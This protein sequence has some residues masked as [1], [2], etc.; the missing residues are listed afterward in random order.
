MGHRHGAAARRRQRRQ[1]GPSMRRSV[2]PTHDTSTSIPARSSSVKPRHPATL[3]TTSSSQE[4]SRHGDARCLPS[5]LATRT[6][7]IL[8]WKTANSGNSPRVRF[9]VRRANSLPARRSIL[10]LKSSASKQ[11]TARSESPTFLRR[12]GRRLVHGLVHNDLGRPWPCSG[13]TRTTAVD[14]CRRDPARRGRPGCGRRC[15]YRTS[16]PRSHWSAG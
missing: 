12:R 14:R 8:K 13:T 1:P 15:P 7:A 11:V 6:A 10:S 3:W 9:A 5:R 4:L 16:R 2:F